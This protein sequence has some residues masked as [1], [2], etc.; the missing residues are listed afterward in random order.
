MATFQKTTI[1]SNCKC[2]KEETIYQLSLP[3]KK[4]HLQF[5]TK[6]GYIESTP[7]TKIGILFV[8]NNNFVLICPFGSNRLQV[9]CKKSN[10][11]DI[12]GD[13]EGFIG[14]IA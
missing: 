10:C 5:F 11:D 7:Y 14:L 1:K 13:F 12:L 8:E 4:N 2:G 6:N 3:I 9:K